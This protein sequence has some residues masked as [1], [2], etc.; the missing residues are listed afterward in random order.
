MQE[1]TGR[2]KKMSEAMENYLKL[3]KDLKKNKAKINKAVSDLVS[4]LENDIETK[5]MAL[6]IIL[7]KNLILK[8]QKTE[9]IKMLK[10]LS[11]STTASFLEIE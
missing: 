10:D 4:E 9:A 5:S 7:Q 2:I 1:I 6:T 11:Q 8:Q 3:C